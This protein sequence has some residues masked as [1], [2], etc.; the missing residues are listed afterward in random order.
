VISG[1]LTYNIVSG[2]AAVT[3][4][5]GGSENVVGPKVIRLHP[6][7]SLTETAGLVHF[8]AN[9]TKKK[10]VIE[11]AALLAQGAPLA[12]LTGTAVTGTPLHL[13][14]N[15]DSQDRK[16]FTMGADGSVVFGQN[17]LT[18][19]ATLNG[20][21]V[22]VEMLANVNYTKGSGPFFGFITFAFADGSTLGVQ[23]Q[24]LATAAADASGTTFASTLGVVG[25]TGKYATTTGTGTFTGSRKA[26]LG[27]T[28]AATFDLTLETAK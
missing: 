18:G 19:T 15:I 10:V 2:T 23:M 1:T 11:L 7:D 28:V 20:E 27:T 8:G 5:K 4:A 9:N 3:H 22:G 6:G 12:T 17:H 21:N 24:G 25:G 26:A 16:L 14:T 13:A